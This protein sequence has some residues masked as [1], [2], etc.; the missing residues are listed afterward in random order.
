MKGHLITSVCSFAVFFLLVSFKP[1]ELA[2]YKVDIT[3][4]ALSWEGH[5]FFGGKHAG[6]IE[7]LNGTFEVADNKLTG[8]TFAIDMNSIRVTDLTGE[9]AEKLANHLKTDDFF[10]A[11]NF[12]Q[13]TFVIKR[14]EYADEQRAAVLGELTIR[15]IAQELA[16]PATITITDGKLN[17]SASNIRVDRTVHDAK[18]GSVRFFRDLGRKI[19]SDEFTLNLEIQAEL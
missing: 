17:A 10:D 11:V 19:V 12:P 7:L 14:V 15:G 3:R 18:Y 6:T 9:T 8:G 2:Q 5:K 4:S 16:F 13:A 1:H